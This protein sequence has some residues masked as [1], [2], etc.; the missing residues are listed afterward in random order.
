LFQFART[1]NA[2]S[3]ESMLKINVKMGF[4]PYIAC[5]VWQIE[6]KDVKEYLEL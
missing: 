5:S 1:E 6:T 3:N 4:K 2:E